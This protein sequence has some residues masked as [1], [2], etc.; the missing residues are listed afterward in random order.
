MKSIA[1][2][3]FMDSLEKRVRIFRDRTSTSSSIRE[4]NKV[5]SAWKIFSRTPSIVSSLFKSLPDI[6]V[7]G[8]LEILTISFKTGVRLCIS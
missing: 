3:N 7:M 5:Q 1:K 6:G 2:I 8:K 4:L